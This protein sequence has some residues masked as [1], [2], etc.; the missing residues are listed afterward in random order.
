MQARRLV[1]LVALGAAMVACAA[2]RPD[3]KSAGNLRTRHVPDVPGEVTEGL[4]RYNSVRHASFLGW[5][6]EE[7]LIGTRFGET[8]QLHRVA[9]PLA[10]REQLTFNE[11]PVG[12]AVVPPVAHPAG[13][14]FARD[15]GGAEF[16]QYYYRD[17]ATGETRLLTD[18]Q[19]RYSTLISQRP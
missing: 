16:Y 14:A 9:G 17:L 6:G 7:M 1:A 19:S 3:E 8:T 2:Q 11:E 12:S 5:L 15:T 13:F 18:G 4:E 10:M